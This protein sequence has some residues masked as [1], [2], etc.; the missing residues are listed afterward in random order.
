MATIYAGA[1]SFVPAGSPAT[2][3]T[4]RGALLALLASHGQA[5][6]QTLTLY[7]SGAASGTI[8][9]RV[10]VAPEASPAVILFPD[11]FPLR[12]AT[13]LAVDPGGCDVSVIASGGA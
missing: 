9:A 1:S 11:G 12:F 10:T 6:A 13:G 5:A 4:G 8:L 3:H 2:I 7:D